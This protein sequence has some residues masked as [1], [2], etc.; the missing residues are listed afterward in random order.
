MLT[1]SPSIFVNLPLFFAAQYPGAVAQPT[2]AKQQTRTTLN[3]AGDTLAS[4][5]P[6]I[7]FLFMSTKNANQVK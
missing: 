2:T 5:R 1:K 4:L 3:L 6:M 7:K